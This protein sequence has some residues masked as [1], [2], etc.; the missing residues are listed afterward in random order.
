MRALVFNGDTLN[1]EERPVPVV[2]EGEALVRVAWAGICNTDLEISRGYMDF[3]GVLGH[4]FVGTVESGPASWTGRRVV[5]EINFGCGECAQCMA[6]GSRH[7]ARRRVMGIV[8]ADGA[9]AQCVAVPTRNLHAVP[10]DVENQAAVFCEPLA[11]AFEIREQL[12]LLPG[13][14]CTVL[15]DGKL[16]LL[17]AQVL[18]DTGLR[19]LAVG[20]HAENLAI[21]ERQG[22]ETALLEAWSD[23]HVNSADLVIEATGRPEGLRL[24]LEAT[25]PRGT[26]VLK[27]T[28]AVS[29]EIDL[30]PLV[31]DEIRL[32]GSR[33]GPFAPALQALA[34]RRIEVLPLVSDRLPLARATEAFARAAQP[35]TRKILVDCGG[36]QPDG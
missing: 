22:I 28:L 5:A 21:L 14:R 2:S 15:G 10:D 30:A 12:A 18:A 8:G 3:Q 24:A 29:G 35:G 32:V 17:I 25:R 33:C 13:Q 16:G 26:L 7:C 6:H 4:E 11:A 34:E 27:S 36:T 20:R 19:V 31:I 9:L 23:D 1:V